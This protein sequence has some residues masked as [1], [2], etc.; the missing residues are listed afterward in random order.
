VPPDDAAR[1]ERTATAM[2]LPV[3]SNGNIPA[4]VQAAEDFVR[5][6]EA[7]LNAAHAEGGQN[8][9]LAAFLRIPRTISRIRCAARRRSLR[10][11]S[12]KSGC[13]RGRGTRRPKRAR[14]AFAHPMIRLS[15]MR[16]HGQRRVCPEFRSAHPGSAR[17]VYGSG[18][19]VSSSFSA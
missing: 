1:D 16:D 8:H 12:A 3:H 2:N 11:R 14:A 9:K 6:P 5:R 13:R 19:G 10:R 4:S 7:R 15:E 17:Y 18:F